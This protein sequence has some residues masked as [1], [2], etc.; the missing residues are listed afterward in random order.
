MTKIR[1]LPFLQKFLLKYRHYVALCQFF[2]GND[3]TAIALFLIILITVLTH[4]ISLVY[5]IQMFYK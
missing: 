2:F 1:F 4:C 5:P 3:K